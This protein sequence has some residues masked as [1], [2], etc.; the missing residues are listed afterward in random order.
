M[1]IAEA[2]LRAYWDSQGVPKD[3]QDQTI[4]AI[5][6]KAQP[7]AKV[8]PYTIGQP[9]EKPIP[10]RIETKGYYAEPLG[11]SWTVRYK[12]SGEVVCFRPSHEDAQEV[13]ER[14]ERTGNF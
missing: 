1:D 4:A 6:E 2:N 12:S 3:R 9:T 10:V 14:L 11:G 7:G 13:M 5:T 8:G